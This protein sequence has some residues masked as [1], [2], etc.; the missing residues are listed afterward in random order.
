MSTTGIN[1]SFKKGLEKASN[2]MG[3]DA[4]AVIDNYQETVAKHKEKKSNAVTDIMSTGNAGFGAEA[5]VEQEWTDEL[6]SM[7]SE[8]P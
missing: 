8:M 3:A 7:I 6:Y 2:M 5:M 1:E 4:N